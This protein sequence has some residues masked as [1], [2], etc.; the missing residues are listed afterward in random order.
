MRPEIEQLIKLGLLP[1]ESEASVE[2]VR[3]IEV[4]VRAI[5]KPVSDSEAMAMV[6]IFGSD[7]CF[8]LAWSILHLIESAPGWPLVDCLSNL[9]NEWVLSLRDRSVRGR[10]L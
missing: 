5:N 9:N 10:K 6:G 3:E 1:S 7:S 8:G 4:L 2:Q